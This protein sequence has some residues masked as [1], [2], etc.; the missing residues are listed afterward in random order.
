[1]GVFVLSHG[2]FSHTK[3]LLAVATAFGLVEV[4][5]GEREGFGESS[6]VGFNTP[7]LDD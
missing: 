7:V 2:V 3:K 1:M 4:N 5:S 6:S